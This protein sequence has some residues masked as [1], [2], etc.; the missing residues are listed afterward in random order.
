MPVSL[1]LSLFVVLLSVFPAPAQ[2]EKV[3]LQPRFEPGTV[4]L[5]TE[6]KFQQS[7][8]IAGRKLKSSSETQTFWTV[9]TAPSA[10]DQVTRRYTIDRRT[11]TLT[12]ALGRTFRFDSQTP[13]QEA[14]SGT[15]ETNPLPDMT[16]LSK[17]VRIETY[18]SNGSLLTVQTEGIDL[19]SLSPHLRKRYSPSE[20]LRHRREE[21]AVLPKTPLSEGTTWRVDSLLDLG[22]GQSLKLRTRYFYRGAQQADEGR[23][24]RI[25]REVVSSKF[26]SVTGGA[27]RVEDADL[28]PLESSGELVFD[29]TSGRIV[30]RSERTRLAGPVTISSG[31]VSQ[32]AVVELT[33][34]QSTRV[35]PQ[36]VSDPA[37]QP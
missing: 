32:E 16:A 21:L 1:R 9:V 22:R 33:F 3:R 4:R 17:L 26:E 31:T 28:V 25:L 35:E 30:Q 6:Q 23:R 10:D 34:S 24:H 11:Q 29:E 20:L 5:V 2:T 19:S 14:A 27:V 8:R 15:E 13:P 7:M 36:V 37:A 18:D 12:D